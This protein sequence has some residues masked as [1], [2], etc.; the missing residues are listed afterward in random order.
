MRMAKYQRKE[1]Q[2]TW[3]LTPTLHIHTMVC[4]SDNLGVGN[5]GIVKN[6]YIQ[7]KGIFNHPVLYTFIIIYLVSLETHGCQQPV[8]WVLFFEE[9]RIKILHGVLHIKDA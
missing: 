7:H 6:I 1:N 3:I 4:S 9:V 8:F 2:K 5:L